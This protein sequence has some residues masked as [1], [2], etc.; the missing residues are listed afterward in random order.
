MKTVCYC[1]L[2]LMLSTVFTSLGLAQDAEETYG[3]EANPTGNPIGGGEGY[4]DIF[5]EGDFTVST[6]AELL[7]ALKE[8]QPGQIVFVP[9]GVEIDLTGTK[10]IVIPEAVTLA[11]TRGL[12]GS[13]GARIFTTSRTTFM[14][15]K[16]GGDDVRVTGL[17]FE[18]AFGGTDQTAFSNNFFTTN[19]YGT[20]VDNCEIYNFNYRGVSVGPG[21]FN[22]YVHHNYIHHVQ[23]SGLGY[24]VRVDSCA[25]SIIANKFDYCRHHVASGGTPGSSYEAAWNL[26]MPHATGTHFDM[27]G[28]RDRGDSTDIAGD[29]MHVHHNTFQSPLHHVG[30]R[31]VPSDYAAIHH[32]WFAAPVDKCVFSGGNTRVYSN[33]YGPEK[34]VKVGSYQEAIDAGM[35][36]Y[37]AGNYANAGDYFAQALPLAKPGAE[38]SRAELYIAHCYFEQGLL[39]VA[40]T[41]F[42]IIAN[43]ADT[44]P[45][46]KA[47]AHKR[48]KQID[49]S[50]PPP[51]TRQW[52]L[53]FN[54][55][56]ERDQLG[57]D[58][59]VIG[60]QWR[61]KAGKLI[62]SS[63]Y[64]EIVINRAFPGCQRIEFE[65]MTPSDNSRPCD[66]SPFIHSA[67]KG[68]KQ[69]DGGY[70][71][72][73]GASGNTLNRIV[74]NDTQLEDRSVQ[75][76][77]VPGKIHHVLAELD[78]DTLRL[79]VDGNTIVESRDPAPIMNPDQQMAGLYMYADTAVDNVKVYTSK[80]R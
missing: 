25:V 15:M 41:Q 35:A 52:D 71:F 32:N 45:E 54:D 30:I 12:H 8:A 76:F 53:V 19:H 10:D 34:M 56:F 31:G 46:D 13:E 63:G 60:G 73:F 26:I 23:R 38:R 3:C 28:G 67:G 74:R 65:A 21:A 66:F 24:G 79:V 37:K 9:D 47:A 17:R 51:S 14:L 75:S 2:I 77:I 68:S 20:E 7:Q 58:W 4:S 40:R 16:T 29:W 72:Q 49:V 27:H 1:L 18:G 69:P 78:G 59:K 22:V 11:G 50:T 70:L 5:T 61:I 80:P 6:K 62:C 55:D 36:L 64:S 43:T 57:G 42:E 44:L 48:L 39:G 33:I